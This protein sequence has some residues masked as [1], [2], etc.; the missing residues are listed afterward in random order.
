MLAAVAEIVIFPVTVGLQ[1]DNS[2]A[3]CLPCAGAGVGPCD[4]VDGASKHPR[5]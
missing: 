1:G 4:R 3:T 5:C 2:A